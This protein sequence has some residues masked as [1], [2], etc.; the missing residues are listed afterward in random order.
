MKSAAK[1]MISDQNGYL[2]AGKAKKDGRLEMLGG[3]IDRGEDPKRSLLRELSEE[4]NGESLLDHVRQSSV[5]PVRVQ[6]GEQADF[7]FKIE[8]DQIDLS[9]LVQ[10][11]DE[12]TA[13]VIINRPTVERAD[14]LVRNKKLFTGRT[15]KLFQAMGYLSTD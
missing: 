12:T 9:V 15:W 3:K 5:E 11:G 13:L 7:V 8:V 6:A 2:F 14:Q 4:L 1:L 10:K